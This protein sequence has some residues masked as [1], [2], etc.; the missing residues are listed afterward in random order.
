MDDLHIKPNE[1][2]L[3]TGN[4]PKIGLGDCGFA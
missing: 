3:C 1:F 4:Y 2:H